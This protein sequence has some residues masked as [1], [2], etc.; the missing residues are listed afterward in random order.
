MFAI[1]GSASTVA[2]LLSLLRSLD[3][4]S[5]SKYIRNSGFTM[6]CGFFKT[7]VSGFDILQAVVQMQEETGKT[8]TVD[9]EEGAYTFRIE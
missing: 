1:F 8:V 6:A 2:L 9:R 4:V 3:I 5:K 7:D